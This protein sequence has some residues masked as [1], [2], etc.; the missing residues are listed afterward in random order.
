MTQSVATNS[1]QSLTAVK[2][3]L[4]AVKSMKA[5][6]AQSE[7]EKREPIAI[8]GMSCRYPGDSDSP[9]KLWTNLLDN[10]DAIVPHPE[11]RWSSEALMR[12]VAEFTEEHKNALRNGGFLREIDRFEPTF[13][14]ISPREARNIDPQHRILLELAWEAF[15][16]SNIPATS[17]QGGRVGSYIGVGNF[18][19]ATHMLGK[20]HRD[21][22]VATGTSLCA[23]AG[24]INFSLGFHGPALSIET[25]CSSSLVAVQL[26][27]QSL[28]N[29]HTDIALAGAINIILTPLGFMAMAMTNALAADGRCKT[30]DK[31][32]D[33]YGRGEGGGIVVLK[34][35]S[36]AKADGDRIMAVIH[37]AAV[38]HD[39]RSSGFTTPNQKA[40]ENVIQAALAD[41]GMSPADISYVEAHGTGTPLGDPI[42]VNA[43]NSVFGKKRERDLLIGSIKTN[44]GHLEIAAGMAGL[45]K[46]V[47]A[48]QNK[49]IPAHL[50]LNEPNELISWDSMP[51]KVV[52]ENMAWENGN[53]PHVAGLSSFGLTGT[54]SHIIVGEAPTQEADLSTNDRPYHLVTV[55][56]RNEAALKDI[57]QNYI[58]KLESESMIQLGDLAHTTTAGRSH[59]VQRLTVQAEN[60]A[61]VREGLIQ[62]LNGEQTSKVKSSAVN[63]GESLNLAMLFTGQGSQ[64]VN[65]G[66]QLYETE[67]RFK[68]NLDRCA[69]LLDQELEKP[70]FHVLFAES[71][72]DALINLTQY[73]QPCLFALEYS[74]AQ[75]WLS[76]GVEPTY[77]MGHSVGEYVAACLAGVFSLEDGI[78]LISA[79]GRLMGAL[80]SGGAMA[81]IL[82]DGAAVEEAVAPFADQL[83]IGAYNGPSNTVISGTAAA[84]EEV[85]AQFSEQG[86]RVIPL[87]VSH[88]FH[89]PLM[90]PMLTEFRQ[91]AESIVFQPPAFWLIS[92][93][94]GQLAGPEV[95]S[96]EYWVD[97]IRAAV[98]F[99]QAMTTLAEEGANIFL[100]VGPK[101]TLNGMG[102]RCV[103][104]GTGRWLNSLNDGLEDLETIQASLAQLYRVGFD[105]DWESYDAP[106]QRNFV[107]IPT[108]PFQ[109]REFWF[110]E[111]QQF[112]ATFDT[113]SKFNI[114]T[115]HPLLGDKRLS[116]L[117]GMQ[118]EA[119]W[120]Y[121]SVN[122]SDSSREEVSIDLFLE[123]LSEAAFHNGLTRIS[124]LEI[125]DAAFID[126][127]SSLLI[128]T[129]LS[130]AQPERAASVVSFE[131]N[132]HRWSTH[133]LASISK[134]EDLSAAHSMD[135]INDCRL[136][137]FVDAESLYYEVEDVK[138]GGQTKITYQMAAHPQDEYVLPAGLVSTASTLARTVL[139]E[140][141]SNR[142]M[143]V[144]GI[145]E[146]NILAHAAG[147]VQT[148]VEITESRPEAMTLAIS[149]FAENGA[150]LAYLQGVEADWSLEAQ[151]KRWPHEI[152]WLP[153][154]PTTTRRDLNDSVWLILEDDAGIAAELLGQIEAPAIWRVR[155]GT[156]TAISL[157]YKKAVLPPTDSEGFASVMAAMAE[158]L[159]DKA[160][161]VVN[162]WP[163]D[164]IGNTFAD[165]QKSLGGLFSLI[166]AA[167]AMPVAELWVVTSGAVELGT[168]TV[169][170]N[171]GPVWAMAAT[172]ATENVRWRVVRADIELDS[173]PAAQL[174]NMLESESIKPMMVNVNG[175]ILYPELSP[176]TI[177]TANSVPLKTDA[178]YLI[179][180][181]LGSLGLD[182]AE[183][184]IANGATSLA[185][186]GRSAPTD[187]KLARLDVWRSQGIS[188]RAIQA[189]VG[190]FDQAKELV[191]E[192]E[193]EMLPL[194][195]IFHAAGT[196][197]NS[198]FKDQTWERFHAALPAKIDGTWNLHL[199]SLETQLDHF[200]CFSST[201]VLLGTPGLG[202]YAAASGYQDLLC[203]WRNQQGLPGLSINWSAWKGAGMAGKMS[204]TLWEEMGVTLI[205]RPLGFKLLGDILAGFAGA[206]LS[207]MTLEASRLPERFMVEPR[208]AGLSSVGMGSTDINLDE[209]KSASPDKAKDILDGYVQQ[210][211]N[212][213]LDVGEGESI[214][215]GVF[216]HDLGLDSLMAVEL[217]NSIERDLEVDLDL[218]AFLE[219]PTLENLSNILL[220]LLVGA[221]SSD[222]PI[223]NDSEK[224]ELDAG[225]AS[226]LLE[227]LDDLSEEEIDALLGSVLNE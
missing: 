68:E 93:V 196:Q 51:I 199:A 109:R 130:E 100:E 83:S 205:E 153:T 129:L 152:E 117:P 190:K 224:V 62:F 179:T 9:D 80:P 32:A 6:L 78:R 29:G 151:S 95:E 56:A 102:R 124:N 141:S 105:I 175:N 84:V 21:P 144:N 173:K 54:N 61:S 160:I 18:E 25:A 98:R 138:V 58:D 67:P 92:N 195:G 198:I 42:E 161:R 113:V 213:V 187:E 10:F 79:R 209:L 74:L 168:R 34:R 157:K 184:L 147:T 137:I 225:Q 128:Q 33:G 197:D 200:V 97:H 208:L 170:P 202:T 217:R 85:S 28:R 65:M 19:Y 86:I 81:A 193:S 148:F 89:S 188:I 158:D 12:E 159:G 50:H 174:L 36:D 60:T 49:T 142:K 140:D 7:M 66:R 39:G 177:E 126:E 139:L 71:S 125:L 156:E 176:V 5:K 150:L 44:I 215:T 103:P 136:S 162:C 96:A 165:Q 206:Q 134:G 169:N 207:I 16:N 27:M 99:E 1:E 146:I 204:E 45:S 111:D 57:A 211:A 189:D 149:V 123:T 108:Y 63:Q 41:A 48:L 180:G 31:L 192:I 35:L 127:G 201:A 91:V 115:E 15:E 77:V 46:V 135:V 90:E 8:V 26:A 185:L 82:T 222:T 23:A 131:P 221:E 183:W 107:S 166:N 43:L 30:F 4:I 112:K 69:A 210:V 3:A 101:P 55:S 155:S 76:W 167:S 186:T 178:T 20:G 226:E 104:K 118:F 75:L 38:N 218:Q 163:L 143:Y 181:G 171:H 164:M 24:R 37:G 53:K 13:F 2:Q 194:K 203:S 88:A 22:H 122:I 133:A 191:E 14:G 52:S 120:A 11:K 116:P 64:Y 87:T 70:F 227:Q 110:N 72:D 47:L 182:L 216:L 59:F 121:D 132:K 40:Q 219:Q 73:T 114:G 214:P 172:V 106:F 212:L 119:E 17:L 220:S 145:G 223:A 94:S 154:K